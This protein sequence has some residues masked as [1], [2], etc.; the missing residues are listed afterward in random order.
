M[1]EI[2]KHD[3][4]VRAWLNNQ[5]VQVWI[6]NKWA[7]LG[8]VSDGYT[9]PPFRETDKFRLKPPQGY[10]YTFTTGDGHIAITPRRFIDIAAA[11]EVYPNKDLRAMNGS[12]GDIK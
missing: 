1:S 8:K 11:R 4:F 12:F 7:D 10:Q 2:Y 9:L 6:D 5:Q 3:E